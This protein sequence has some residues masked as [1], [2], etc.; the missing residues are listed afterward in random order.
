MQGKLTACK[1]DC[2]E[3]AKSSQHPN[4]KGVKN[5]IMVLSGKGGVGKS[6][7]A[8]TLALGLAERGYK[9]GVMDVDF[10][11]PSIPVIFGLVGERVTGDE[12]GI[13]PVIVAGNL[14]VISI[15]LFMEE[16][17]SAVI[18]RGP[19][20]MTAIRQFME[21]IHWGEL[22]YLVIDSPPGTGDEPLSVAQL[23]P[24]AWGLIVTTPQEL[25]M[26]DVRK[27]IVFCRRIGMRI[28]GVVENMSGLVCPH[29]GES[30]DI[31]GRGGAKSMT[32][33]MQVELLASLPLEGEFASWADRGGAKK[34][35][36]NDV[37][38][39]KDILDGMVE[40]VITLT[41]S[42]YEAE[43]RETGASS[44]GDAA[45]R[46]GEAGIKKEEGM[47]VYAVPTQDGVLCA[48]FG[49][50]EKFTL[51]EAGD[52][53]EPTVKEV[54]DAPPHEPGLLPRWLADKGVKTVIAGGMGAR[55]QEIF[56]ESGVKVVCGAPPLDP[57]QVVKR[58]VDG[59]LEVGDNVCDH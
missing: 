26:A 12:E 59:T 11:G 23:I 43:E 34:G 18:W 15:G 3:E 19:L 2:G 39:V 20:K 36:Y 25:A 53:G 30:I 17:D 29:C 10:H 33:K 56:A 1:G 7:V 14:K 9:V 55:A 45:V 21:E 13:F 37:P 35:H 46:P 8:A 6:S 27:S 22:D 58:F 57:L 31:F 48:H 49:H 4:F 44:S 40:R 16:S 5:K 38:G 51:V 41:S 54:C 50:C 32:E 42:A 47:E 24:D 52:G 28:L